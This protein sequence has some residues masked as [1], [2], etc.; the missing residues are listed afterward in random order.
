MTVRFVRHVALRVPDPQA[1][2]TYLGESFGLIPADG[3]LRGTADSRPLIRLAEGPALGIDHIAFGASDR[4]GVDDVAARAR[5]LGLP[6]VEEPGEDADGVYRMRCRDKSGLLFEVAHAAASTPEPVPHVPFLDRPMLISHVVLNTPDVEATAALY[7]ELF[8]FTVS[9]RY[10][11]Y[12]AFLRCNEYHHSVALGHADHTSLNHI[13]F[14]VGSLD[15]VMRDAARLRSLGAGEPLWGPGRHGPGDNVFA[16]FADPNGVVM[17]YTSGFEIFDEA[18]PRAAM[19]WPMDDPERDNL[20]GTGDPTDQGI[21]LMTGT[22]D[23]YLL[24]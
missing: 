1:S 10:G 24:P 20:W 6:V 18:N 22:P 9:D 11:D 17:E 21:A 4:A 15:G 16:Y 8:G 7:C 2:H 5:A 23:P 3:G 14:E 12:M 19:V 13:A